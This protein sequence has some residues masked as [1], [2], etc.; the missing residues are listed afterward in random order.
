MRLGWPRA[1]LLLL[2]VP[3]IPLFALILIEGPEPLIEAPGFFVGSVVAWIGFGGAWNGRNRVADVGMAL[4]ALQIV[5]LAVL[6]WVPLLLWLLYPAAFLWATRA[7]RRA[8]APR[9]ASPLP[10]LDAV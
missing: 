3:G 5:A 4:I 10:S 9:I 2:L 7:I 8:V 1:V 6:F